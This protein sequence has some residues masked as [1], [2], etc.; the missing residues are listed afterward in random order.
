M[1]R[2]CGREAFCCHGGN[3]KVFWDQH[4]HFGGAGSQRV[5]GE[6]VGSQGRSSIH[7]ALPVSQQ[8]VSSHPLSG[9]GTSAAGLATPPPF[10]PSPM[11]ILSLSCWSAFCPEGNKRSLSRRPVCQH[12]SSKLVLLKGIQHLSGKRS[13]TAKGACC[14]FSLNLLKGGFV[15]HLNRLPSTHHIKCI[16]STLANG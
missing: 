9:T 2:Q 15:A 3:R 7:R 4:S 16:S 8:A 13:L 10:R 14:A 11:A 6:G 1:Q 12:D 5:P